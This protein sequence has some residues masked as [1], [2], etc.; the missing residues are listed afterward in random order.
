MTTDKA[1]AQW[2]IDALVEIG[3]KRIIYSPGSRN[4][5]LIIAG[6]AHPELEHKTVLDERSAAFQAIGESLVTGLP[7]AICCTSGSALANY[8]PAVLEAFY[9][10]VPLIILTADRPE[11]RIGKGEGQTSQQTDFYQPHIGYSA[12]IN[13][14]VSREEAESLWSKVRQNLNEKSEPVH[15]NLHFEEPLYGQQ[16]PLAPLKIA[17]L[18]ANINR[19]DQGL[20]TLSGCS[21]TAVACGQLHPKIAQQIK[22]DNTIVQSGAT[23]FVDP[24]SGLLG[25]P[26][27]VNI[28]QLVH[29]NFDGL[30]SLG[31]QWM[32]KYPKFHVR[33]LGLSAH[34]HVDKYQAWDLADVSG[35]TWVK[36][37]VNT[38]HLPLSFSYINAE[39]QKINLPDLPWSDA[40][41]MK[42]ILLKS[43]QHTVLHLGNSSI[44]RYMNYFK[45]EGSMYCNRGVSGIDGSLS[46]AVGA[47]AASPDQKHVLILGDQS[48]LYDSNAL[49]ELSQLKNL[50]VYVIN[51]GRGA[52]FDWLPGTSETSEQ[53]QSV[54]SNEHSVNIAALASACQC[55]ATRVSNV[56][57][58]NKAS[59]QLIEVW[60]AAADNNNAYE[61]LHR[62]Y[63]L[64]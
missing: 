10:K 3:V 52:I 53:A 48:T 33:S 22:A 63:L 29:H 42:A 7:V 64:K 44:P 6:T 31:G 32:S 14:S 2:T 24:L 41:A 5:P 26:N 4:T 40:A 58:L 25:E 1:I 37:R 56:D 27:T 57:A 12:A 17:G 21:N 43:D 62:A 20:S 59:K 60:T 47:A 54:Y 38:L 9:S 18:Q 19:T 35:F 45:F 49:Y 30:L 55:T 23:W 51:N 39:S 46:T 28:D 36:Q 50:Q 13:E 8:H 61:Q 15:V 16:E 11:N 34:V